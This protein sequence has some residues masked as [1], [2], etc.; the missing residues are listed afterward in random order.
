MPKPSGKGKSNPFDKIKNGV[1]DISSAKEK[2]LD[3][4]A[5]PNGQ[6]YQIGMCEITPIDA[7]YG[8]EVR[9]NIS[10]ESAG[11]EAKTSKVGAGTAKSGSTK[12]IDMYRNGR[13]V[14]TTPLSTG[15]EHWW[16]R[17]YSKKVDTTEII[18]NITYLEL[19]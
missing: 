12:R 17:F 4:G 11:T 19:N 7:N 15:V 13:V 10:G 9:P 8:V 3:L 18:W 6:Q 14:T 5:I 1:I 2:W 16:L